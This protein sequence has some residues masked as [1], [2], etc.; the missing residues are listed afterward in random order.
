MDNNFTK[1]TFNPVFNVES[2]FTLFYMEIKKDF[3]YEG[4]QHNFWEMVYIDKAEVVCTAEKNRFTLKNGEIT[5]HKPNEFHNLEG[6]NVDFPN[7]SIITFECN[8]PSMSYF[9]GKIFK[10]NSEEKN[11]L[12]QLFEEGLSCFE[13]ENNQ[14]PLIQKMHHKPNAPFGSNQSTKNLLELF[15]IKLYRK[16]FSTTKNERK[17]YVIDGVD[18]PHQIKKILDYMKNHICDR[19]SIKEIS[20]YIH[21]SESQTKKLFSKYYNCGVIKYFNNLKIQEAKR[22][23]REKQMN[24]T[25]IAEYLSFDTPQYFTKCFSKYAK[26]TPVEYK[27]SILK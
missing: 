23:I 6:N 22:L 7:V 11:L 13:M 27:K 8:S 14:N 12:S 21:T 20:E 18:V 17:N 3:R 10:L 26:M 24:M 25:E 4:E 19:I 9:E 5:F 16:G 15:L 2:V 1:L